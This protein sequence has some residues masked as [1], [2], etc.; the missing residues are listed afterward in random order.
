MLYWCWRP[1]IYTAA[2]FDNYTF[3]TTVDLFPVVDKM[4]SDIQAT[5]PPTPPALCAAALVVL[6]DCSGRLYSPVDDHLRLLIFL[7]WRHWS[8]TSSSS[9]M[10]VQSWWAYYPLRRLHEFL[11]SESSYSF[12]DDCLM[13]SSYCPSCIFTSEAP[14]NTVVFVMLTFTE[15]ILLLLF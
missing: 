2:R 6:S 14:S 7:L 11:S 3:R 8:R 10:L 13:S 15:I 4:V 1:V 9:L 12:P 5:R